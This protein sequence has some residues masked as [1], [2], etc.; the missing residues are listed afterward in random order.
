M[1]FWEQVGLEMVTAARPHFHCSTFNP[2]CT[3]I[4]KWNLAPIQGLAE[5]IVA[6]PTALLVSILSVLHDSL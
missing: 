2:F 1:V 6:R 5:P 4:T 3:Q